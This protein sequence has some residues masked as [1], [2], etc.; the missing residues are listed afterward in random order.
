M[1]VPLRL[2]IQSEKPLVKAGPLLKW[3]GGKTQLLPELDKAFPERCGTFFE[4]FIGGASVFFHMANESRFE[5]AA[6]NDWNPEI[7]NLYEVVQYEP[8]YLMAEIDQFMS[9][10]LTEEKY[11]ECRSLE[12]NQLDRVVA[13]ARTLY[14]NKLGF[15]GLYR[16]NKKG[17][18]NVP[19]GKKSKATVYVRE[20]VRACSEVLQDVR[21]TQGDFALCTQE[22]KPGDL[23]YM[24]PPY[25]PLTDTSN[26]KSYTKD[27]FTLEDQ[28]RVRNEFARLAGLGVHVVASNSDTPVIRELYEGFDIRTVQARRNINSKGGKRGPVNE[29]LVVGEA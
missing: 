13:A 28:E 26:F 27:G 3:A 22:A 14:L 29:V 10:G 25:V 16:Q 15:N 21:V 6:I 20:N 18:F 5:R 7:V 9:H 12:V 17:Q 23:V 8:E 2:E 19:W 24:D 4:P 1:E 11:Y